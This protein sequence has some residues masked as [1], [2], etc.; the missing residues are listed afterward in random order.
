MGNTVALD[1]MTESIAPLLEA[2]MTRF[3]RL[4]HDNAFPVGITEI[5]DAIRALGAVEAMDVRQVRD[6]L[7][8]LF[9]STARDWR[10]FDAIF[11][12]FWLGLARKRRS[13][14]KQSG[15][16]GTSEIIHERGPGQ[17][18][19]G[20][21]LADYFDWGK[22]EAE[23]EA[24]TGSGR[25]AG[26]S[27]I[28]N[29]GKAD[30]GKVTDPEE[31]ERLHAL[32]E[33][34]AAR[35][36]YRLSRRRRVGRRGARPVLRRTF[37]R[38]VSTGG[39]P[40]RLY[41]SRRKPKPFKIVIFVDVSGSM[42]LYSL[43]FTRFVHAITSHFAKTEAFIFH[44]QLVQI[45]STLKTADPMKLMEK[46]ALISQGWSGGTRIGAALKAFN[47]Q[48]A[49]HVMSSRSL[50]IIVSDGFDTGPAEQLSAE[51]SR[52]KRRTKRLVW[53]NPLLGRA[54]YQPRAAAMAAALPHID[55]FA[56]AHNLESLAALEDELARL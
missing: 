29:L 28:E 21:T 9:A 51:L 13:V 41:R 33:Q 30:F 3:A 20:G 53:L 52:L 55:L 46:M 56:P 47:D 50:A 36:R 40:R 7:R 4:L 45:T 44:T 24:V 16:A 14:V 49:G 38:S 25:S 5:A 22:G 23:P 12:A 43:F 18:R 19:T 1:T 17:G 6:T 31:L 39:I 48:Y 34:W 11:D 15:V 42:D 2:Q 37:Q 27:A 8:T 32:A 35:I 10:R 26:A 54:S